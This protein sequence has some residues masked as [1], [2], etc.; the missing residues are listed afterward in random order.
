M[1]WK[2]FKIQSLNQIIFVTINPRQWV[3]HR[4]N[5]TTLNQGSLASKIMIL[6][7]RK[8]TMKRV[9]CMVKT[10]KGVSSR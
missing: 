8:T 9:T 5:L 7:V 3:S 4:P 10:T 2:K 6:I 1:I